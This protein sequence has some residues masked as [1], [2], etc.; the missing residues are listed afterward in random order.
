MA[1]SEENR[2]SI[3]PLDE[4]EGAMTEEQHER[5]TKA[6]PPGQPADQTDPTTPEG[7]TPSPEEVPISDEDQGEGQNSS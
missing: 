5:Q 7:D 4:D 1:E 3:P 6:P 2:G